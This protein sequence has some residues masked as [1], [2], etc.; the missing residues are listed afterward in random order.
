MAKMPKRDGRKVISVR[1]NDE[2][3]E[4]ISKRIEPR[5]KGFSGGFA[6]WIRK[7][8]YKELGL[9]EPAPHLAKT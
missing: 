7:N 2:A 8:I 5:K 9:E 1:L 6:D 4:E 3:V